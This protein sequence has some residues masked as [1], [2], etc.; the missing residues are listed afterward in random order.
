MPVNDYYHP[1]EINGLHNFKQKLN[2]MHELSIVHHI[3]EIATQEVKKANAVSVDQI[4]LDIG[5]LSGIEMEALL[6][7]WDACVPNTVLSGAKRQ[8][9]R[10]PATSQCL[11]CQHEFEVN[12]HFAPC[13]LCG[14]YQTELLRGKELKIKSLVVEGG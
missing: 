12:D 11:V 10:I 9:N 1:D 2:P 7:A 4:D 3:L 5:V 6:F 8:I 14:D 13:P